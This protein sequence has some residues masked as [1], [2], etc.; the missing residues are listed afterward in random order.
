MNRI[1]E[2]AGLLEGRMIAD[3]PDFES[4]KRVCKQIASGAPVEFRGDKKGCTAVI[5]KKHLN[6]PHEMGRWDGKK[7]SHHDNF[8]PLKEEILEDLQEGA[9][10]KLQ[11][12]KADV[13]SKILGL[14]RDLN[15]IK[16][17]RTAL[18]LAFDA[19]YKAAE[20]KLKS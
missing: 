20:K 9:L 1:L 3:T 12:K 13:V 6:G 19:G 8:K 7:G 4:W 16:G 17:A 14:N 2:L 10:E 18:E 11:S 5:T 15:V